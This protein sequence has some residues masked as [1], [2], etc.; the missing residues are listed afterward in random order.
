MRMRF[1]G[2]M[3]TFALLIPSLGSAQVYSLPSLTR[4]PDVTAA[5]S[6]WQISSRPILVQGLVFFPTGETRLFDS[7]VMM[8]TGV[9]EGVP[10]YSDSTLEPH[11][12]V[13]VPI[14]RAAMRAYERR[15]DGEL[16]G[17]TGSR[18]PAF[19]V[20][21]VGL[22]EQPQER[23]IATGGRL[24]ASPLPPGSAAPEA[25]VS[26]LTRTRVESV[27]RPRATDG[28]WIEFNGARWY[29]NGEAVVYSPD[30]FTRI[31]EYR[32]F[33]VYREKNDKGRSIWVAIV[34]D[35]PLAPYSK[36]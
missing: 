18:T 26:R 7:S 33:P 2:G 14:G 28:I 19:P 1:A 9:F 27:P 16:A 32:G 3:L 21:P 8:Q 17:T 23:A 25:A 6:E 20:A 34:Q 12:V 4:P 13:Y 22:F 24:L 31:G 35:G 5:S 30:R 15:R 29:S 10:V 11:S 36:R